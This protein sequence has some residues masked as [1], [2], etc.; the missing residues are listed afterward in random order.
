M[1]RSNILLL[2]AMTTMILAACTGGG[3]GNPPTWS[4]SIPPTDTTPPSPPIGLTA[5]PA[6]A[7]AASLAWSAATDNMGVTAYI[8]RR[9]GTQVATSATTTYM[10]SGLSA[11]TTYTY[12]VAALDAAGNMSSS[13][14]SASVTTASA[15]DTTPPSQ[16]TG[17]AA[18][19]AGSSGASLSWS[20]STDNVGV[21]GYIVRRNG[22][23]VATPATT[24]FVDSGLSPGTTY[25]YAVA[26]R[27]AAGNVSPNSTS[28]SVTTASVADTTPPSQPAAF[29]AVPAGST[30]ATLSWSAS[31]DNVRVT[32]YIV[33]R[34]G[35]Q[36]ATLTATNYADTGL[37]PS[38]SYTYTVAARDAAGNV[39][40][41]ASAT[42]TTAA[43][44]PSNSASL[45]W[46]PVAAPNLSGYRLYFGNATGAYLQPLGQG[47]SV[48]NV[49]DYTALGLSSATRYYFAVTATDT[50]GNESTYSNEVFKD[51]P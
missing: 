47:I 51:I 10:D 31:T 28:V 2:L 43:P 41:A 23:Q 34:N 4:S 17:L 33:R 8:V 20:A 42:V 14:P 11:G 5:A 12:N 25:S 13:S 24:S 7:T 46:D 39:S 48:G 16:P 49:T 32:G 50:L 30:N 35:T 44:P 37:S 40:I 15:A 29:T 27:D 26:A 21:T 6:G 9:N 3:S 22:T 18:A 45:A 36:I 1:K 19:A 38:T